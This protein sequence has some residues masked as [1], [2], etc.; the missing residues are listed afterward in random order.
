MYLIFYRALLGDEKAKLGLSFMYDAPP[1][2]KKK[3]V[4]GSL[5]LIVGVCKRTNEGEREINKYLN[6]FFI[7]LIGGILY[8]PVIGS[9]DFS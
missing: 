1:G 5:L 2:L 4:G 9:Q 8:T 7:L 3:E 6:I